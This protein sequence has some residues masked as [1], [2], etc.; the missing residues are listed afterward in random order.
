M[1]ELSLANYYFA[2][3]GGMYIVA[4]PLS[5]LL[6]L[7][8]LLVLARHN[9]KNNIGTLSEFSF[10]AMSFILQVYGVLARHRAE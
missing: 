6:I 5:M 4:F 10:F 7:N 1:A 9:G 8:A 2:D 3:Y